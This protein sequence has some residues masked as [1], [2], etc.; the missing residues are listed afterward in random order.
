MVR[1]TLQSTR[2]LEEYKLLKI[3]RHR[4]DLLLTNLVFLLNLKPV[5]VYVVPFIVSV[6]VAFGADIVDPSCSTPDPVTEYVY[7]EL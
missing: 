2:S 5:H 4:Q 6:T 7:P 3:E 1:V